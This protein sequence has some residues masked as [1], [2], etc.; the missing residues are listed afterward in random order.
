MNLKVLVWILIFLTLGSILLS[1]FW[2]QKVLIDGQ[3]GEVG[4]VG[5]KQVSAPETTSTSPVTE[6]IE[7]V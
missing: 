4:R 2:K 5:V 3:M 6:T 1:I 7:T